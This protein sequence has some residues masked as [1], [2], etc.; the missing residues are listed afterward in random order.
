MAPEQSAGAPATPR[1]D[2]YSF[3]VSLAEALRGDPGKPLPRWI[4]LV[5]ARGTAAEPGA[6]FASMTALLRA[7]GRDPARVWRRRV[8]VA[9]VAAV[10][11]AAFVIGR[12]GLASPD[13][14]CSGGGR[15]IASAWEP[16]ARQRELARIATLSP[17]GR[18]VA[19]QLA[20][21]LGGYT[22][23]W[24]DDHRDA[25][26]AHRR[27]EQSAALLDRRMACL[28]RG[29]AA[30][31]VLAEI[32]TK[33]NA[34][35][36]PGLASA[37]RELPEP[38]RCAGVHSLMSN[39]EP[40]PPAQAGQVA[41]ID[42]QI[43][44]GRV[45]LAA[46]NADVARSVAAGAVAAARAIGYRPLLAEALLMEGRAL[47]VAGDRGAAVTRL[48][49]ATALGL[50][51]SSEPTG[52]EA[53]ARRA[54]V[55]GTGGHPEA[56]LEGLAVID[57]LAAQS[58]PELAFAR[59]LLHTNVAS[60]ELGQ[61]HRAEALAML[62][63]ALDD[64]RSVT[65][66]GAVELVS[67][68]TNA[69]IATDDPKRRDELLA[70]AHDAYARLLGANH[71]E[72][73]TVRS[74]RAKTTIASLARAAELLDSVCRQY[75]LHAWLAPTTAVCWVE[76]ADLRSELDDRSAAVAALDRALALG[77][78]TNANTPEAVG[79]RELWR[80]DASAA[81][82]AFEAALEELAPRTGEPWYR[83][84]TRARVSLGLG[85][86]LVALDQPAAAAAE[87]ERSIADLA[88]IARDQH[89]VAIDRRLGRARAALARARAAMGAPREA[90]RAI[91]AAA[92]A[93]LG[94]AGAPAGEITA[95][96]RLVDLP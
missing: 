87:L 42:A 45:Q 7:L 56:A 14:P 96:Q 21:Q 66:P 62:E 91:A 54:W 59:A 43:E 4:D 19:T 58:S 70:D 53:W 35:S 52:I 10:V 6:R 75:A 57:A 68:R 76:L 78:G 71:P 47:M 73:I 69:A 88:P 12:A 5:I 48:T 8:A 32:V 74:I 30:V 67:I 84:Y 65:G 49:E 28:D 13:E 41:V 92:L 36:L 33:A 81:A 26:L 90:T 79:Y 55:E 80:G 29:R 9:A 46:G 51:S 72:T 34:R 31:G 93:W 2:Q 61:G 17:Y 86:A 16:G 39:A 40:P 94:S 60:V 85:R 64:A 22:V 1:A 50:A 11:S 23:R 89:A 82:R 37:T 20:H 27:G 95:L 25:C 24:A 15:A 38:D 83:A 44:R 63:R 18:E 77:A 3:G